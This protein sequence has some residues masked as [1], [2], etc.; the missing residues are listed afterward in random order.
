MHIHDEAVCEVDKDV[1][2]GEIERLM[3]V[4]PEW[5]DGCPIGAEAVDAERYKK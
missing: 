2:A 3:S 1:P 4:S 5:L